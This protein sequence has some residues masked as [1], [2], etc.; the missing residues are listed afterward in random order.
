MS[1]VLLLMTPPAFRAT[2]SAPLERK[3]CAH[4]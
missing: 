3:V 4:S 2:S 1:A